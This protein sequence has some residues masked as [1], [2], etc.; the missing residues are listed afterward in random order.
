MLNTQKRFLALK[1]WVHVQHPIYETVCTSACFCSCLD[2]HNTGQDLPPADR[3]EDWGWKLSA[4]D[5]IAMCPF[6][7]LS[8]SKLRS[9]FFL[10]GVFGDK[11]C[12]CGSR[13]LE[14]D[15]TVSVALPP[16]KLTFLCRKAKVYECGTHRELLLIS[17]LFWPSCDS[18]WKNSPSTQCQSWRSDMART[19]MQVKTYAG[20]RNAN[21]CRAHLASFSCR[22]PARKVHALVAK[23]GMMS[24]HDYLRDRCAGQLQPWS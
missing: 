15:T 19:S 7:A 2:A 3:T 23:E 12:R 16:F 14:L 4:A 18:R 1:R 24:D 13:V 8:T 17:P 5:F 20:G 6:R 10:E 22:L 9:K 21:T 11:L